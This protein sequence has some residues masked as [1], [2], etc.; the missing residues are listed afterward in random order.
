L[1]PTASAGTWMRSAVRARAKGYWANV[2]MHACLRASVHVPC[3]VRARLMLVCVPLP[4]G[5]TTMSLVVTGDGDSRNFL[6]CS[7]P[8]TARTGTW[9]LHV[10]AEPPWT[11]GCRR[12]SRP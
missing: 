8:Q 9:R 3:I 4:S 7:E 6:S 11:A 2:V 1:K 10:T 12:C 5:V